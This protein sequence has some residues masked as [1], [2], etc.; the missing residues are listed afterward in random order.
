MM[1]S[2]STHFKTSLQPPFPAYLLHTSAFLR[3]TNTVRHPTVIPMSPPGTPVPRR[4][5]GEFESV[6]CCC[7]LVLVPQMKVKVLTAQSCLPPWDPMDGSPPGC[8]VHGIFQARI[9]E[10]VA[11]PFSRKSSQPRDQT[12]VSCIAGRFFTI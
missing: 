6:T 12:R 5:V 8:S 11:M 7:V 3:S 4:W 10:W 2:L 9:L 1:L